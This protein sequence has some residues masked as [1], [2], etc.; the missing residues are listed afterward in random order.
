MEEVV[1]KATR[2][3]VIG[4]HVKVL[5]R[6]GQLPA[7]LYGAG[8]DPT[9]IALN[10]KETSRLLT[11]LS[12]SALIALEVDG[13]RHMVLIREK[14]RNI[15]LG[16]LRHID[17]LA[18]S[19]KKLLKMS[20]QIVMTGES[21]AVENQTG[22]LVTDMDSVEVESLPGNLPENIKVDIS[23]LK[24]VGDSVYVRDLVVPENVTILAGPDE[25]V[26]HINALAA[27][28]VT[29]AVEEEVD[30]TEPEVIERGKKEE[31]DY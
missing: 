23:P 21:E 17:F 10:L 31:E 20:I 7:V 12:P 4:K 6:E 29:E 30:E 26:A 25:V 2:R 9:P 24:E 3:D 5:L 19:M 18:V 27:E 16:T 8:V 11:N 28:E 22:V 1:L 14:Q 13:N 15:M